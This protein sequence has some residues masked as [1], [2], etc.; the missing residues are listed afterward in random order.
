M[1]NLTSEL[2]WELAASVCFGGGAAL[3]V[4]VMNS[5]GPEFSPKHS[6]LTLFEFRAVGTFVFTFCCYSAGPIAG[7][8]QKDGSDGQLLVSLICQT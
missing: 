4:S 1:G 3:A 7:V 6:A 8:W 5:F 2:A